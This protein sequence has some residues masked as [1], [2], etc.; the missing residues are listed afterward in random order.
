M[1]GHTIE[2]CFELIGYPPNFKKRNNTGQNSNNV[3]VSG[4][5]ADSSAG[6]SHTLTN[7]QYKRLMSLLGDSGPSSCASQS[8]MAAKVNQVRSCKLNDNLIIH[9]VLVVPGY[10]VS[11]ISASKLAKHCKLSVYFNEKD[12]V[13]QDSVLKSQVGTGSE[14]D[15]L[16]HPADQVLSV[17][18]NDIDLKGDFTSEPFDVCHMAKQTREPFP[19]SDHKSNM[20]G[21]LIHLGKD[22]VLFNVEVFRKMLKNQFNKS[23]KV[24]RS[25]NGSEF[26]SIPLNMWSECILTAVYLINRLPTAVLSGKSHYKKK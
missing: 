2:R 3:S 13:I 6:V 5:T 24:S 11:L 23:V 15:G 8:N 25:D 20:V 10:H 7:D 1:N 12:C 22:E 9:D 17:L 21:Q 14:K 16:G 19:L 18:K 26:G 4:K